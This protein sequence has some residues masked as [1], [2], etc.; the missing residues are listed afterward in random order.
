MRKYV[1]AAIGTLSTLGCMLALPG[2]AS[3]ADSIRF[4]MVRS[5]AVNN[6]GCA[7]DATARV[8]VNSLGPV[9]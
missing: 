4:N 9:G 7:L 5:T 8:T 3:A 1:S 6:A 2:T